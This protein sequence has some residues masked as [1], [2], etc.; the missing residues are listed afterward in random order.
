MSVLRPHGLEFESDSYTGIFKT[1]LELR[2]LSF[3]RSMMLGAP[4]RKL[5]DAAKHESQPSVLA[6]AVAV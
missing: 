5:Q 4:I 3:I 6:K 1:S 2:H